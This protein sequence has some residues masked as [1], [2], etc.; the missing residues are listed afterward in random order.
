MFFRQFPLS[1]GSSSL[2]TKTWRSYSDEK[3]I[4]LTISYK[5]F[6]FLLLIVFLP[7]IFCV[8]FSSKTNLASRLSK[9]YFYEWFG[10]IF[11]EWRRDNNFRHPYTSSESRDR[12]YFCSSSAKI[13]E[14]MYNFICCWMED[15][16][17]IS[18]SSDFKEL[19]TSITNRK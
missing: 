11:R 5:I 12:T 8:R 7:L 13:T 3:I 9:I 4:F 6:L 18:Y 19:M 17:T 1:S 14:L 2:Y 16:K 10:C 15:V